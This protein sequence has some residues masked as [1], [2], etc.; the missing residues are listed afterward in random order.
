MEAPRWRAK[1]SRPKKARKKD[2]DE[3]KEKKKG[4][5]MKGQKQK[6]AKSKS[7]VWTKKGSEG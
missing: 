3:G 1:P 2:P 4:F 6:C 5:A 7:A